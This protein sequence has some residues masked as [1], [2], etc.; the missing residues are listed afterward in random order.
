VEA[1]RLRR[2]DAG[3]HHS[4]FRTDGRPLG[5]EAVAMAL[6]AQGC[7]SRGP[8]LEAVAVLVLAGAVVRTEA[9]PAGVVARTCPAA[10]ATKPAR[11]PSIVH[12][13]GGLDVNSCGISRRVRGRVR[14]SA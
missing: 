7:P 13:G 3:G 10:V 1:F 6:S 2:A 4:A 5:G 9:T 11:D 12:T 8:F 14:R